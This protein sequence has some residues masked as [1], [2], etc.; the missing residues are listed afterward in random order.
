GLELGD[1]HREP[2]ITEDAGDRAVAV[3]ELEPDRRGQA[4]AHRR[5]TVRDEERPRREGRPALDRD[6]LVV[7]DVARDKR[8][9]RQRLAQRAEDVLRRESRALRPTE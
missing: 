4:V 9:L 5:E 3:R 7:P 8:V 6:R 2:T 1:A